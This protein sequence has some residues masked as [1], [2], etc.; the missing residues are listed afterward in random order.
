MIEIKYQICDEVVFF[1]T[2]AMR[3]E[4]GIVKGIQ[5]VPTGISVGEDGRKRLDG[6]EVLYSLE[7]GLVLT[8]AEVFDSEEEARDYYEAYF[9]KR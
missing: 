9:C 2:A 6:C 7:S 1:N 4:S 8:G 5:V 3:F